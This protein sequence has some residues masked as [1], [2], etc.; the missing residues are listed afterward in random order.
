M[1]NVWCFFNCTFV[2]VYTLC[3]C[4]SLR[5]CFYCL[6][7]CIFCEETEMQ[8]IN[9]SDKFDDDKLYRRWRCLSWQ[10]VCQAQC[11]HYSVSK[12][13]PSHFFWHFFPNGW[14]L[15]VQILHAYYMFLSTLDYKFSF[16]YLQLWRKS[17]AVLSATTII[18]SKCPPF[19]EMHAGWSHY[20][21]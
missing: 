21:A 12:K 6:L 18:C 5:L 10:L 11:A 20:M 3:A 14:E 1:P 19:V 17:Y 8:E 7:V 15:L 13:S 4:F 9:E 16:N 2:S